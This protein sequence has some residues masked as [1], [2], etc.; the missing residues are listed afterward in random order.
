[1]EEPGTRDPKALLLG[2][3]LIRAEQLLN[4][5]VVLF[6]KAD[7]LLPYYPQCLLRLARFRGTTKSEFE[8]NRQVYGRRFIVS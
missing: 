3:G 7:R 5:A 1:M 6:G 8:D 2:L 4:V